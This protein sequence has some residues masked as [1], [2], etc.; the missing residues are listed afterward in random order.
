MRRRRPTAWVAFFVL[1]L[2][3]AVSP[4]QTRNNLPFEIGE[5]LTYRVTIGR[6]GSGRGTMSVEGPVDVRGTSTY[7]LR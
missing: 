6:V 4:A 1:S 5:R 7:L 2:L 3:P